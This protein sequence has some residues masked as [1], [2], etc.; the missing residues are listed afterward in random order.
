MRTWNFFDNM[1]ASMRAAQ[2]TNMIE[3]DAVVCDIGCGSSAS[4]LHSISKKIKKGIGLDQFVKDCEAGNI[5]TKKTDID[6][7]RLPPEDSSCDAVLFLAVIEHLNNPEKTVLEI[8]R[9]LKP[10]GRVLLTTP[11]PSSRP[12]LE[13]LA[14]IG[15]I[16]KEEVMDHKHYFSKEEMLQILRDA[17]FRDIKFSYFQL[18]FNQRATAVK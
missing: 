10:G 18:G 8:H 1:L 14:S 5:A 16:N 3:K 15:I 17:K 12:L 4:L 6:G 7:K 13:F 2:I 11:S 9:I